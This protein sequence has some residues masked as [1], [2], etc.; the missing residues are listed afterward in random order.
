MGSTPNDTCIGA[1]PGKFTTNSTY[2]T[3]YGQCTKFTFDRNCTKAG[4]TG[5]RLLILDTKGWDYLPFVENNYIHEGIVFQLTYGNEE[6]GKWVFMSPGTYVSVGMQYV[7]ETLRE[8]DKSVFNPFAQFNAEPPC[9]ETP[10]MK[11]LK[12]SAYSLTSCE[13]ECSWL[14]PVHLCNCTPFVENEKY[15]ECNVEEIATCFGYSN[16]TIDE[17][18]YALKVFVPEEVQ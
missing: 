11:F 3:E 9:Q 6:V 13:M 17:E 7:E 16:E 12:D 15:R 10:K 8:T 5:G 18:T 1:G 4:S 2:V 14:I